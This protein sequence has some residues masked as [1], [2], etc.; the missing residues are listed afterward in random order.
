MNLSLTALVM[1]FVYIFTAIYFIQ[2]GVQEYME[3]N[4]AEWITYS[5]G[6]TVILCALICMVLDFIQG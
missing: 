3:K 6:A 5:I 2:M 4:K 1:V